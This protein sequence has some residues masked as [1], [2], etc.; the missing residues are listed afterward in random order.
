MQ[1]SI[2]ARFWCV[3]VDN[4]TFS[5]ICFFRWALGIHRKCL[6]I[7]IYRSPLSLC[8]F[9]KFILFGENM[10]G[11]NVCN[12]SGKCATQEKSILALQA[13]PIFFPLL[14][15]PMCAWSCMLCTLQSTDYILSTN[16]FWRTKNVRTAAKKA[17]T[18]IF[19]FQST[20]LHFRWI[21]TIL[22]AFV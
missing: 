20:H 10:C 19:G 1:K 22:R 11:I 6:I 5:W 12:I 21:K 16:I 2:S 3:Y 17:H 8:N 4:E 15:V 13:R 9:P 18:R 7:C 14:Y